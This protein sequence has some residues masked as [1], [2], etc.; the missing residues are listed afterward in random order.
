MKVLLINGS[1]KKDGNTFTALSEVAK[2]IEKAGVETEFFHIGKDAVH[3]CIGCGTCYKTKECVFKDDALP[4]LLEKVE[5]ADGIVIGSPT[6]FAG[7]NGALCALLDR[8]FYSAA[9]KFRYKPGAAIAVCRRGGSSATLD[10]LNKY[11]T[12]TE[13]PLVTSQYWNLV[14][15]AT[16]GQAL[17]DAEGLQTMRTLGKNMAEMVK[18]VN[19]TNWP[20][21]DEKHAWT[22]FIR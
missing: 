15:G 11:I 10:R 17:E 22:N 7:P 4:A 9:D 19:H 18:K 1:P 8:A 2:E 20:K 21:L 12:Y 3:G 13:M 6:Y 14:F 5:T 16:P